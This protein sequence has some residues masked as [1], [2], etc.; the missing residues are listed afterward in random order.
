M[1]LQTTS[2]A[3]PS[4]RRGPGRLLIGLAAA[5]VAVAAG[6]GLWQ[7]ERGGDATET[8]VAPVTTGAPSAGVRS[9]DTTPTLYIVGSQAEAATAQAFINEADAVRAHLGETSLVEQVVVVSG[10]ERDAFLQ[11][12][13]EQD[14]IR[15]ALGL[16]SIRVVEL[17]APSTAPAGTTAGTQ[18]G[19]QGGLAEL[20]RDGGSPASLGAQAANRS[21][22]GVCHTTAEARAC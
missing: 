10:A 14:G 6:V 2:I 11:S 13:R 8:A 7:A 9:A 3:V 17:G 12:M 1:T 16:P 19:E 22:A 4:P 18:S 21:E 20:I 15:A 5:A